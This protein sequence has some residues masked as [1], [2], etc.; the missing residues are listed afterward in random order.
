M[1]QL[2]GSGLGYQHLSEGVLAFQPAQG[3]DWR[4]AGQRLG[5]PL[6]GGRTVLPALG[7]MA[8]ELWRKLTHNHRLMLIRLWTSVGCSQK[9]ARCWLLH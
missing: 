1:A 2:F 6:R 5:C 3:G 7:C 9:S 4:V 8:R